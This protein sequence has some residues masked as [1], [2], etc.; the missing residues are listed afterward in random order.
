MAS[1]ICTLLIFFALQCFCISNKKCRALTLQGGA[2]KGVYQIGALRAFLD[3]FH[4]IEYQYQSVVGVSVGSINANGFAMTQAGNE[5][6]V[7]DVLEDIWFHIKTNEIYK[8]W[9]DGGI[10]HGLFFESGIVDSSPERELIAVPS[11][12]YGNHVFRSISFGATNRNEGKYH[13]SY[14]EM[15]DSNFV[16][17]AMCSSAIPA[18]FPSQKCNN[19]YY[20]DGGTSYIIDLDATV[21]MC[22]ELG[23]VDE[24]IIVDVMSLSP[25]DL[26]YVNTT[27]LTSLQMSWR[28]MHIHET[29]KK[30]HAL[31][32]GYSYYNKVNWRYL[33]CPNKTLPV[34]I[35]GFIP[36]STNP[37]KIRETYEMGFNDSMNAIR[38][39][40]SSLI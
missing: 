8:N 22:R 28:A 9:K 24:D 14:H 25:L 5:T 40:S 15:N 29:I 39:K 26:I 32:D 2:L 27:N 17:W 6:T 13:D 4:P 11:S 31:E 21:Q 36:L 18:F 33:I 1:R 38:N 7:I 3:T 20:M 12:F 37:K 10:I 34:E 35:L 19:D 30:R 16:D 23:F